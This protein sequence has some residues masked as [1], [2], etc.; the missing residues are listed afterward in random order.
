MRY[1]TS[2]IDS[3]RNT[4]GGDLNKMGYRHKS[5]CHAASKRILN[6]IKQIRLLILGFLFCIP[7]CILI[8]LHKSLVF[9]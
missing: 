7:D 5:M 4:K 6:N 1:Y 2:H 8:V 9:K 3:T